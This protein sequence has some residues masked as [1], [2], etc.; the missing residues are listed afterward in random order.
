MGSDKCSNISIAQVI[1]GVVF[2]IFGVL[3][4]GIGFI[5]F[6]I[7]K[8]V[9]YFLGGLIT[10]YLS[11]GETIKEP[12]IGAVIVSV[13]GIIF[14]STQAG[15]GTLPRMIIAGVIAFACAMF[16]ATIGERMQ[17]NKGV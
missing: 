5:L 13:A 12:A 9:V 17:K 15:M 6:I 7:I 10:G 4:L 16:G 8:P 11:P 3:T 14:D 2:G 1:L